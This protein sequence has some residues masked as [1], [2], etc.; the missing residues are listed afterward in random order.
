MQS[1][2]R[3]LVALAVFLMVFAFT[4]VAFAQTSPAP[5]PAP[6]LTPT[7]GVVMVLSLVMGILNN[8][9]QTGTVLGRWIPPQSWLPDATMIFTALGGFLGYITS[10]TPETLSGT[11]LFYGAV[12]AVAA[13]ITGA[14]PTFALHAHSVL[15]KVRRDQLLMA[16]AVGG[17]AAK[18]AGVLVLVVALVSTQTA[19]TKT[20]FPTITTIEQ[21]VLSDIQAGK[22]PAQIDSD[23]CADLGG[24][25][26]TDVVCAGVTT[27]V[28]DA[29]DLLEVAGLIPP[30]ILPFAQAY[31]T[32]HPR[33][34]APAIVP[35]T[36]PA[37]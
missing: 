1:R 30:G 32:A 11:K 4:M 23:V 27:L 2:L 21:T 22:G 5:L 24:S 14:T 28:L 7:V 34:S 37:S 26:T 20:T 9:I 18:A 19:C 33:A 10:Q 15:T 25:S 3:R 16:K 17:A 6:T 35:A 12:A 36:K 31:Q 13:L 8:W 29:I